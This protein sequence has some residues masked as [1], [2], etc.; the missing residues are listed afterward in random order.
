MSFSKVIISNSKQSFTGKLDYLSYA[1]PSE[2][3]EK[4]RIG[5]LVRVPLGKRKV[6]ALV[7]DIDEKKPDEKFAIKDIE[8]AIFDEPIYQK[9]LVELIKYTAEYCACNYED[10]LNAALPIGFT[11][12]A[13]V[14][15][16]HKN[17]LEKLQDLDSKLIPELT[18]EQNNALEKIRSSKPNS[19]TLLHGVTGSGKTEVYLRLIEDTFKN[20]KSSLILIPEISLA[21]QLVERIAQ[22]FG[23][24]NV[25][26]WHSALSTS[27]RK[28]T[29]QRLM[30][31]EPV[32]VVGARS[33]VWAPIKDLGLIAIDEEHENSYKQE[34][35]N[36]RYHART[37]AEKRA[38]LN[39]CRVV[40]G[41]ATPTVELYYKAV[42][43]LEI[44]QDYQLA[45]LNDRVFKNPLPSV[46]IVDMREEFLEGNKTIFSKALK[47]RMET[48]LENKEQVILFLN[49]RGSASHVF[50]RTCGYVYK[51]PNCEAK[52]V[53]HEENKLMICHHCG[54]K[55]A[56]PNECPE[57][58]SPSIKFFGLG[59]QKL[60]QETKRFFPEAS[61]GRLDS[62]TSKVKDHYLKVLQSFKDGEIDI[63][64][65]TQ[66][67]AKGID[68][69]NL[70]TVGVISSDTNFNQL[71]YKS[72]ERGFQLLTQVAGRAGRGEKEGNAIFQ[73]HQPQRETLNL[74]KEQD[75]KRF[76]KKE[77]EERKDFNYPPFSTLVRLVFSSEDEILAIE[78][79]NNFHENIYPLNH[80][81]ILGPCPC[82]LSKLSL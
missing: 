74:A 12:K 25:V 6:N 24:E 10:V 44:Y 80:M 54:H 26:I 36:P 42:S 52:I 32:V 7:I 21:P 5:G 56:H 82:M 61:V 17:P 4:I 68:V 51:C 41:S 63:L 49:K 15:R 53:Y 72:E 16:T 9:E 38:E 30:T 64:V 31:G 33:A 20:N 34:S 2:L 58:S 45:E 18:E 76:Y 19:K 71:E 75:Y 23:K 59:T 39:N 8:E 47:K 14:K 81:Q 13:K 11:E 66:M 77:I 55:E 48:A 37:I 22:R 78:T 29:W 60:E 50:C 35:P 79:A 46:E 3:K 1:I 73:T 27:E 28:F 40:Y 65:G 62:D 57:C 70:N 67:I 69:V 43:D